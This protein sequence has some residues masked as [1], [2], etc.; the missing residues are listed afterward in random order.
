[1]LRQPLR[2][3]AAT[4]L[5]SDCINGFREIF[6]PRQLHVAEEGAP[7]LAPRVVKLDQ[8]RRPADRGDVIRH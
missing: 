7:D 2:K 6:A 3:T 1:M 4:H 5:E 8:E